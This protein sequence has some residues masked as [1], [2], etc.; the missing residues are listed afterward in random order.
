M[1]VVV[2]ALIGLVA[3]A[4]ASTLGI[5]GGIVFVPALAVVAGFEQQLAE[6]T[7]LAVIVPTVLV[8]AWVHARAGR[9]EWRLAIPIGLGGIL[10]GLAGA[11]L[12][13][14]VEGSTLRRLFAG[15]VLVM[16]FRMLA[17][18]RSESG[19]AGPGHGVADSD[20]D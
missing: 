17:A 18:T 6:G 13:L 1:T 11:W 5:G 3:G 12:A 8:G 14:A 4:L 20:E 7:S 9:V 10:G 2:L 15:F 16:A 19:H